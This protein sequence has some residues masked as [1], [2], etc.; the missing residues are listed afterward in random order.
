MGP[1]IIGQLMDMAPEARAEHQACI[2][3]HAPLSEQADS[4]AASLGDAG[5]AALPG[6]RAEGLVCAACHVRQYRWYGPPRR[7]GSTAEP[8]TEGFPHGAWHSTAAFQ[9]SRFCAACHQFEPDQYALNGKPIENTF[10]EWKAS[11]YA[12]QGRGCQSCHMSDRRHLW[13]GI[14]DPDTVRSGVTIAVSDVAAAGRVLRA[15]F[16]NV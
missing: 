4:L 10:E 6:L 3:C 2:R 14:H 8:G 16:H 5:S 7:D 12:E 11:P 15:R 1:G 9:S 13:R